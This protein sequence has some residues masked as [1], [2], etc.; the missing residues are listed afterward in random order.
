MC[1]GVPGLDCSAPAVEYPSPLPAVGP[2]RMPLISVGQAS[3]SRQTLGA[4]EGP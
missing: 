1:D 2:G 4:A 3:R